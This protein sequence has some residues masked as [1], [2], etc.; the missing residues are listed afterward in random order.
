VRYDFQHN[1]IRSDNLEEIATEAVQH[2]YKKLK[3]PVFVEDGGLFIQALNGF[4]GTYSAWVW[5]KISDK[6]I[7]KLLKGEKNRKAAFKA[8]IAFHDGK[9]IRSFEGEC[10]G[11]VSKK[12]M[13]KEGFGYDPIF[14]P[15]GHRTSFAESKQLKNKLSHRYKAL[16]SFAN[17]L[18]FRDGER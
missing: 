2:A 15:P 13:G 3:K 14:I 6:G 17:Y 1:E 4:P 7:L 8:C 16:A 5:R 9:K 10:A 18:L 11:S 12:T